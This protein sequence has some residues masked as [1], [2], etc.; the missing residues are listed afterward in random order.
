MTGKLHVDGP[1]V[2]VVRETEYVVVCGRPHAV[3]VRE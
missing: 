2:R 3:G 1:P